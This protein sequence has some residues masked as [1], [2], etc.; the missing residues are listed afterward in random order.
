MGEVPR[1]TGRLLYRDPVLF[2]D[3][4]GNLGGEKYSRLDFEHDGYDIA[5]TW[6]HLNNE[7]V[8]TDVRLLARS[9]DE[10]WHA[11]ADASLSNI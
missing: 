4:D 6:W 8:A 7:V 5:R 1:S 11:K 2:D 10:S 9:R 3:R